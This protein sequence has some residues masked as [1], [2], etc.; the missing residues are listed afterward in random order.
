[1]TDTA[2]VYI[3]KADE[4]REFAGCGALME[5]PYIATC[6]HVWRDAEGDANGG[7]IVEFPR[8]LDDSGA[9]AAA[10]RRHG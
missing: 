7:V 10:K 8:S 2:L 6:R 1:M 5:G 9:P 4:T 3:R